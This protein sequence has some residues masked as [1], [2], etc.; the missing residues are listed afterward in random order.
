MT[1][2]LRGHYRVMGE[3]TVEELSLEDYAFPKHSH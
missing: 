1:K 3:E 2:S